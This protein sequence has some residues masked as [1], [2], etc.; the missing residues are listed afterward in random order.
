MIKSFKDKRTERIFSGEH[1]KGIPTELFKKARRRLA[2]LNRA[3]QLEDMYFPPSNRFHALA[4]YQPAR[5]A[6]SVDNQWR[7]TFEWHDG[8]AHNVLFEDYH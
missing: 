4:G 1:V 6:I 2:M 7:I 8:D 3:L 5:Y